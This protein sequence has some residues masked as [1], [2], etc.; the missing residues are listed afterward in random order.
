MTYLFIQLFIVKFLSHLLESTRTKI[1]F[2]TG[3]ISISI[4]FLF[5]SLIIHFHFHSS[6]MYFMKKVIDTLLLYYIRGV[7]FIKG[8]ISPCRPGVT[9]GPPIICTLFNCSTLWMNF[10]SA[11][12]SSKQSGSKSSDTSPAY[13]GVYEMCCVTT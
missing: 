3:F 2:F 11:G 6:V 4:S 12:A 9:A 10:L 7:S 5:L 8:N 1:S 13:L